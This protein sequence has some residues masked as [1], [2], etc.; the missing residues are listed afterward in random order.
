MKEGQKIIEDSKVFH[1]RIT[2]SKSTMVPS[3]LRLVSGTSRE[4]SELV[5]KMLA[6]T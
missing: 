6:H 2:R 4:L 3:S 5:L 1:N